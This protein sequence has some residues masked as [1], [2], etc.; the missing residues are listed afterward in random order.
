MC[1]LITNHKFKR[2]TQI[3]ERDWG[4]LFLQ[5][6]QVQYHWRLRSADALDLIY[7]SQETEGTMKLNYSELN[8]L[9]LF[10]RWNM[11][12]ENWP[13]I[14]KINITGEK[15]ETGLEEKRHRTPKQGTTLIRSLFRKVKE[16]NHKRHLETIGD[17]EVLG[18]FSGGT[19][20][21]LI[22]FLGMNVALWLPGECAYSQGMSENYE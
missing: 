5:R 6:E 10:W 11:L 18:W 8:T 4:R 19:I 15:W 21:L 9:V 20:E 17:T 13:G 12:Q 16:N 14:F 3:W 1:W 22:I 7:N 2:V